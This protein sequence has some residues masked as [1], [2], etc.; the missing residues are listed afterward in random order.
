MNEY[1]I[2]KFGTTFAHMLLSA[3]IIIYYRIPVAAT[4][5]ESVTEYKNENLEECTEKFIV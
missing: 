1:T 2:N 4:G 3:V 5:K